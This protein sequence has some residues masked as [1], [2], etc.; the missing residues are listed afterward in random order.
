MS[1]E[2]L[3]HLWTA[4]SH[5][6]GVPRRRRVAKCV[7]CSATRGEVGSAARGMCAFCYLR[8]VCPDHNSLMG[9]VRL[10]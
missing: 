1:I 3:E 2:S 6:T 8:A 9:L 5:W 10:T 7:G 4:A